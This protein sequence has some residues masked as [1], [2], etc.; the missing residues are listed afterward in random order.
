[1]PQSIHN[2]KIKIDYLSDRAEIITALAH[3]YHAQWGYLNP[4]RQI[5]DVIE[6]I[7]S[8]L[9]PEKIPTTFRAHYQNTLFGSAG[10]TQ[11]DMETH[12][13]FSPWLAGVYVDWPYRRQ[14]IGSALVH[15]VIEEVGSMGITRLYLFTP[16]Q[17]P[18]YARLGWT[19][20]EQAEVRNTS[21]IIMLFV[22]KPK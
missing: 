9:G 8:H 4:S 3:W 14:G 17:E 21:V 19:R 2:F 12:M 5:E 10:L 11:H 6:K 13:Q 16:D 7:K 18:F 1:M 22:L 15:R 20:L